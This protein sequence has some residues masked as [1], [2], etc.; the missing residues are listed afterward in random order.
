MQAKIDQDEKNK[1]RDQ[2]KA[3]KLASQ[4]PPPPQKKETKP[5][6]SIVENIEDKLDDFV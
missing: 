1:M 4:V 3:E 6:A 5:L 2:E